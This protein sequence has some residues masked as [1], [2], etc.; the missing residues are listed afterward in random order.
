MDA[1]LKDVFLSTPAA[2]DLLVDLCRRKKAVGLDTEF[3]NVDAAKQSCVGRARIHVFSIAVRTKKLTPLGFHRCRGWVLPRA[4]LEYPPVKELLEDPEIRKELHNQPVDHH[5]LANHGVTLRGARNTLGLVRWTHPHLINTVGRFKLKA[6]MISLLGRP[7][8]C[9]FK[10]LVTFERVETVWSTK[11]VKRKVCACGVD[12]CRLRKG[13]PKSELVEELRVSR[14]RT[15]EDKY[16][17]ET[18]VEGH[19]RWELLLK[20]A[21]EDAVAALQLAEL[22]DAQSDPA[23]WPY[24]G[25][26]PGFSQ[27]DEDATIAMEAVGIPVDVPWC[28]ETAVR[29]AAD[30]E[31]VLAWLF[32]WY[33][34][35]VPTEG[36]HRRQ[37][38]ESVTRAGT[39]KVTKNGVDAI[40]SSSV[41]KL[42]LFDELGFPRSPIWAKGRVKPGKAKLDWKAMEWIGQNCPE[43][44]PLA[45][46]L[47]LLGRIRG[48]L[49]YLIK[50]RDSGGMVHPTCGPAGDEDDRS[51][52]VTG[53]KAIKGEFP[54][55]QLPAREVKDPYS[56]RRAVIAG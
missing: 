53:R 48:N 30:E 49:N 11:K 2:W 3:W 31:K 26:R 22:C 44:K 20:Y 47:L 46:K 12:K 38:Q 18:I 14:E 34:L 43:S 10:Q 41:K 40:W 45:D 23:P 28:G 7:P 50:L 16:P 39:I 19:E 6:L 33:V 42:K 25:E 27:E 17:L 1:T 5:A 56:V 24:E 15:V 35:N 21:A 54:A 4:A 52:A 29:A 36:P 9:S 13:H 51:G 55:Q 8:I 32:R 37:N